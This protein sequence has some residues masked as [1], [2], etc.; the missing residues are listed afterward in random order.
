MPRPG[1]NVREGAAILAVNSP[2]FQGSFTVNG[3]T[4]NDG[5]VYVLNGNLSVANAMTLFLWGRLS[6]RLSN[7]AILAVA[8]PAYF[9][10]LVALPFTAIPTMHALA[11]ATRFT[12]A[13]F[14][15][16]RRAVNGPVSRRFSDR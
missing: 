11:R 10:C 4:G 9:G 12:L 13:G 3:N 6:D 1:V 15:A 16:R 2:T 14:G 5:D 8:L 7:K